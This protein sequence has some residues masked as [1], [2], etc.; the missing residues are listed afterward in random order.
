MLSG[1]FDTLLKHL[2]GRLDEAETHLDVT[3]HVQRIVERVREGLE[4]G[5]L[6]PIRLPPF[7]V[8]M[9][10]GVNLAIVARPQS[11]AC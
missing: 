7:A 2:D 4:L 6:V 5:I 9:I 10:V 3:W 11:F 8:S 1:V